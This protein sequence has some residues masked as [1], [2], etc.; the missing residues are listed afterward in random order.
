MPTGSVFNCSF[1]DECIALFS[2]MLVSL[3]WSGWTSIYDHCISFIHTLF[4]FFFEWCV[5][6][7]QI[8][9][10]TVVDVSSLQIRE[11]LSQRC[12][13][14][15]NRNNNLV[16]IEPRSRQ[17]PTVLTSFINWFELKPL[18]PSLLRTISLSSS[19]SII[20]AKLIIELLSVL[21][22]VY[23]FL[24]FVCPKIKVA[25]DYFIKNERISKWIH[26]FESCDKIITAICDLYTAGAQTYTYLFKKEVRSACTAVIRVM[27]KT[28]TYHIVFLR[29]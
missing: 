10:V 29:K 6:W 21:L 22:L 28:I 5:R 3:V 12:I 1:G 14:G 2:V 8:D 24:K 20:M 16:P 19:P 7:S 4:I 18:K 23:K 27:I 17:V 25:N 15:D 13:F 26:R 9:V 11:I